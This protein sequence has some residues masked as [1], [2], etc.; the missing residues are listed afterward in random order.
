MDY[1]RQ[2]EKFQL[3]ENPFSKNAETISKT[4]HEL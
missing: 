1:R 2:S 3:K 4:Y